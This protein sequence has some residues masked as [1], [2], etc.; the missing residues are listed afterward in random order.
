MF[1]IWDLA[2]IVV[3]VYCGFVYYNILSTITIF[4]SLVGDE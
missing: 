4:I 1:H 2:P 3:L